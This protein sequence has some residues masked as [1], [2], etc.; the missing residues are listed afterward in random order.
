MSRALWCGSQLSEARTKL[1]EL[2][3]ATIRSLIA[4]LF[5]MI[6]LISMSLPLQVNELIQVG[7]I[8]G[9]A[10]LGGPE[11]PPISGGRALA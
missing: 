2:T 1:A 10:V 4:L 7:L 11:Q 8:W 9:H 6:F 3:A 5:E